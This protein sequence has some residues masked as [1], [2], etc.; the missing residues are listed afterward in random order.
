MIHYVTG[1]GQKIIAHIV[2][3]VGAWGRGFVL[4]ISHK[5]PHVEMAYRD[6]RGRTRFSVDKGAVDA[7]RVEVDCAS[8]AD[9]RAD[10]TRSS[11]RVR[12][13][14]A[15]S[16]IRM[17]E[18]PVVTIAQIFF[19]IVAVCCYK[20]NWTRRRSEQWQQNISHQNHRTFLFGHQTA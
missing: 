2:N 14:D 16:V 5:W 18:G 6:L 17:E 13:G 8:Q 20:L 4:A 12:A 7:G 3:D 11:C 10:D 9:A 1:D 19:A 15:A